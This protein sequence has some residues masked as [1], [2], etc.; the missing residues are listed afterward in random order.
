MLAYCNN[1]P[2]NMI[3]S[4][5][6]WGVSI[7][8]GIG[9]AIG[10]FVSA[11][12]SVVGSPIVIGIGLIGI[13]GYAVYKGYQIYKTYN[14][15]KSSKINNASNSIS[16]SEK[17]TQNVKS[18][19]NNANKSIGNKRKRFPQNHKDMY[20]ILNKRGRNIPDGPKT[21]GRNKVKWRV[22]D[23]ITLTFE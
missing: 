3:D 11:V 1:N 14:Y 21:K 7:A 2:I 6:R 5:G 9:E 4:D 23:E 12:G 17:G 19:K 16:N 20:K 15:D 8:Y 10:T 18:S 22:D 13:T